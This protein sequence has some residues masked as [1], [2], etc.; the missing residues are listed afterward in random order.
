MRRSLKI[1][2]VF[3]F[4]AVMLLVCVSCGSGEDELTGTYESVD[5]AFK[6][7]VTFRS[8][9][10]ITF[11]AFK[12]DMSGTYTIE[13]GNITYTVDVL[14]EEKTETYTFSQEGDSVFIDGVEYRKKES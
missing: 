1:I 14:G 4:A 9:G 8:G 11:T 7:S 5:L 6:E 10:K 13:N 2:A 12:S 3:L